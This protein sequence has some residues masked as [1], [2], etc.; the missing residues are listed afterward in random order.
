MKDVDYQQLVSQY[1]KVGSVMPE[2]VL[3]AMK[4]TDKKT[5]KHLKEL[6]HDNITH[7]VKK[8]LPKHG[9][10]NDGFADLGRHKAVIAIGAGPSFN[11]NQD[12]LKTVSLA[13]G[14]RP[15]ELQ[16][17][18]LMCSNHQIK[19]CLD[20]GIIPHFAMVADGSPDL[21]D[22]MDVGK[23]GKATVLIAALTTHPKV[24]EKWKGPVR[25]ISQKNEQVMSSV[26]KAL[27]EKVDRNRG[28]MEGGNII[29]MSFVLTIGLFRASVW[30]CVG[31]DLSYPMLDSAEER[32][33]QYY[34][35][36]DYTSNIKSRRDEAINVLSWAGFEYPNTPFILP[37]PY[38]NL[39]LVYTSPQMFIYK[40]WLETNSV[41]LWEAGNRFT[42][43]NCSEGGILGV[44]L[45]ADV[46]DP[47][48]YDEKFKPE[49]WHLMDTVMP[50]KWRTRTLYQATE[51]FHKAKEQ[52]LWPGLRTNSV[53]RPAT[54]LVHLN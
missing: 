13:D 5:R 37:R 9:W 26:E 31:N 1:P 48:R 47:E 22:Q 15:V 17:F 21:V 27:G 34:A 51:E 8:H 53:A 4:D 41:I 54:S 2:S 16:D 44:Q 20:A 6:W 35:D 36:G 24:I 45:K 7:N 39:N 3:T 42:L 52:L 50:S 25:F 18:I 30:M 29:N 32:R 19:P 11:K 12:Y 14:T 28:V 10:L 43:Y 38:V 49:N 46:T 33:K 40:T 23:N